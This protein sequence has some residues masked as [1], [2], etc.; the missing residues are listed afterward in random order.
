MLRNN[1]SPNPHPHPHPHPNPNP[2]PNPNAKGMLRYNSVIGMAPWGI[3]VL[4]ALVVG[5]A[6]AYGRLTAEDPGACRLV[7]RGSV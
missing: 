4:T 7:L 2:N 1:S 6:H 3:V 5:A